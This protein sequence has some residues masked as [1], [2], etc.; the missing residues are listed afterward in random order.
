[1]TD[2]EQAVLFRKLAI[3]LKTGVQPDRAMSLLAAHAGEPSNQEYESMRGLIVQGQRLS[4][5][6][7]S[8]PGLCSDLE[9]SI[10][11]AGET[12]HQLSAVLE[13]LGRLREWRYGQH[14][15]RRA[16]TIYC[17]VVFFFAL[18]L[19]LC[20]DHV[21]IP[22]FAAVFYDMSGD[23]RGL[24]GLTQLV[25]SP[26]FYLVIEVVLIAGGLL[27]VGV[28]AEAAWVHR[29]LPYLPIVHRLDVY[30]NAGVFCRWLVL[31][32][33]QGVPLSDGV[34]AAAA[35]MR[36]AQL[37]QEIQ[38]P[39][40]AI[41]RGEPLGRSLERLPQFPAAIADLIVQGEAAGRLPQALH[42]GAVMAEQFCLPDDETSAFTIEA[43]VMGIA[44]ILMGVIVLGLYL[45]IFHMASAI[46]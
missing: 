3:L 16:A 29:L 34:A 23:N 21:V 10:L 12:H 42:E 15:R 11:K 9:R 1:M 31:A 28:Y 25:L 14:S 19:I 37:R 6:L 40:Q 13:Q 38:N 46:G 26:L 7:S 36:S 22:T 33:E 17:G 32:L 45:P 24:P 35:G 30:A 41:A 44:G 20:L 39:A 8:L 2:R 5:T 4:D 27:F 18:A 43:V